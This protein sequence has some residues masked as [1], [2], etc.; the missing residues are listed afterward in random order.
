MN[1]I[2]DSDA[3]F[4]PERMLAQH[5]AALTLLQGMLSDPSITSFRWLDIACG[6][7]QIISHL[8]TVLSDGYRRKIRYFGYDIDNRHTRTAKRLAESL[9]FQSLSFEIGDLP[10]FP[11]AFPDDSGFDFVTLTNTVH[12]ID[13]SRLAGILV[14]AI[15]QLG[16]TGCFFV[17]DMETLPSAELGAVL[18][19]A[20]EIKSVIYELCNALGA[21]DY[22]PAVGQWQHHSCN[23]WNVQIRRQHLNCPDVSS[24]RDT[25]VESVSRRIR[26]LVEVKLSQTRSALESLTQY[27]A[28][29]GDESNAKDAYLYS[30]WALTRAKG[31][32]R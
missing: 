30:F 18:W 5:Q 4:N 20:S 32:Q 7:G 16:E 9:S 24:L 21:K 28:E 25:V 6:R 10:R 29:T 14:D 19:S 17:Y 2:A 3:Y 15:S 27:G 13:P 1:S 31:A 22:E 11:S 8:K 23:G 26:E 12:E